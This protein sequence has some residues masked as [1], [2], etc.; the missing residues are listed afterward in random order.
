M[1]RS[2]AVVG[3][4]LAGVA[5]AYELAALGLRVQV[6]ERGGS[7]AEQA[8]F[9]SSALLSP[10]VPGLAEAGAPAPLG[11]RLRR[12]RAGRTGG[13]APATLAALSHLSLARTAA[14]RRELGL[15]DEAAE[16]LL[17][18][19]ADAKRAAAAE[20]ALPGWQALGLQV[21]L[22]EAGEARRREPG[23]NPDAPLSAALA[24][25]Q[26]GAGNARL[27]AQQLRLQ[28]QRLGAEFRF[29]TTVR[30]I[31]A[32]GAGLALQHEYTPPAEAPTR[33]VERDAG[34]TLPQPA[35]PQQERFDAVVL[36]NGLEAA[37]LAGQRL[38]LAARHEAAVTAPLRLLEAHP[39]LG[40]KG[41]WVD[42]SRGLTVARSG[43]RV[44]VT[45][46]LAVT[47]ARAK[48]TPDFEALHRGLQHWFPGSVLHQQVQ[49]GLSRRAV[50]ADGLPLLGAAARPGLWLNLS[51]GG[52]GWGLACGSAQLLAQQVA[53]QAPALD[54]TALGPQR[55]A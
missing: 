32:E 2:V 12:W 31:A 16:G 8:S 52:Q 41:G 34:D 14:L 36:C 44:R 18:A 54:I 48:A 10:F 24:L 43:Q 17:V 25:G 40:P 19:L 1:S 28:A 23:L 55:L 22:I 15:D 37:A 6:F 13:D 33:G 35:G 50:P 51:P 11:L 9:A 39:D 42:P 30:A 49:Q 47:D 26:G 21:E 45:G 29:H 3:A 7:V 4:G 53:G 46:G 27:F 20:A 5:T 38:R